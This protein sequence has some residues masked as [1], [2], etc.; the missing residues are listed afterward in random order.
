[1]DPAL[2]DG[3]A[4]VLRDYGLPLSILVA[5]AYL[6]ISGR[7]VSGAEVDYREKLIDEERDARKAAE[8]RLSSM[9]ESMRAQTDLLR[10]IERDVLRRP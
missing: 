7:L 5:F 8:D 1:M 4:S 6:I 9:I 10:E 2:L 3:V